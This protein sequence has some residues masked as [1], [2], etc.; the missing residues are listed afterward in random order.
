MLSES[1]LL[2]RPP[3]PPSRAN[4]TRLVHSSV[5]TGHVSA[6]ARHSTRCAMLSGC[7]ASEGGRARLSSLNARAQA[8]QHGHALRLCG[9]LRHTRAAS[10]DTGAGGGAGGG[11]GE[12]GGG[13]GHSEAGPRA[14]Q[15]REPEA[16]GGI[17]EGALPQARRGGGRVGGEG[18]AAAQAGTRLGALA[19]VTHALWG[20]GFASAC[21]H[22]TTCLR[23][24]GKQLSAARAWLWQQCSQVGHFPVACVLP[25]PP[26]L[27]LSGHAAS[28]R[29]GSSPLRRRRARTA[30][31]AAATRPSRA[32]C[33]TRRAARASSW[34]GASPRSERARGRMRTVRRARSRATATGQTWLSPPARATPGGARRCQTRR[35]ETAPWSF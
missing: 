32:A 8:V 35:Q 34:G 2:V 22:S 24:E 23:A 18:G 6:P 13:G 26:P 19:A 10:A 7:W 25:P 20:V 5:L 12:R 33:G 9:A 28:R 31:R 30:L 29:S 27:V 4:W 14:M 11:A 15:A 16:G 1:V 17:A 3:P 21:T